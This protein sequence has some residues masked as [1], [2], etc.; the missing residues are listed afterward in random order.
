MGELRKDYLLNR[1]VIISTERGKRPHQFEKIKEKKKKGVCFFCPGNEGMTPK[2]IFRVEKNGKWQIRVFPNKYSAVVD[3]GEYLI[4]TDNSFFT[5]SDNFG[6]HEVIVDTPS[7]K[8]ELS[9]LSIDEINELLIVFSKRIEEL[10]GREGIKYVHVFKNKGQGAG[11]SIPHSHSQIIAYNLIPSLVGD[12]VKATKKFDGC[13]YCDIINIEKN[14]Y[15]NVFENQGFI[16]FTPY[17]SRSPLEVW[18]FPKRHVRTLYE[19]NEEEYSCLSEMIKKLLLRLKTLNAPYNMMLFYSPI[20]EDLH[21]H[22]EITPRLSTFAGFE[23]GSNNYINHVTPEDAALFYKDD[24][25]TK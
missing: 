14:S 5:F 21:F 10:S 15:R 25:P 20:G 19:L 11:A 22:I 18:I 23:F 16:S 13:P 8:K 12:K 3:K 9:D 24:H 7:H 2:E 1:Y 4:R 17:A 6:Y